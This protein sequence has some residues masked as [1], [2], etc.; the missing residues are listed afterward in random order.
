VIG[1][2]VILAEQFSETGIVVTRIDR[3]V[4]VVR[5]AVSVDC[6][7]RVSQVGLAI[8][9]VVGLA[10]GLRKRRLHVAVTVDIETVHDVSRHGHGVARDLLA[11]ERDTV[12]EVGTEVEQR[13]FDIGT[14][15]NSVRTL[16]LGRHVDATGTATVVNCTVVGRGVLGH[17]IQY[18]GTR[19][20]K[21]DVITGSI[22][23]NVMSQSY[24]SDLV[25][26][27]LYYSDACR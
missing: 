12:D 15:A 13:D 22:L 11:R 9:I 3:V 5:L 4:I 6:T 27:L 24:L 14:D 26:G 7:F 20:L 17:H 8:I 25:A 10:L 1:A 23:T 2:T 18:M 16:C 19:V 21:S